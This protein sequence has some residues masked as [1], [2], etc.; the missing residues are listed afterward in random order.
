MSNVASA[1]TW[2]VEIASGI[3]RTMTLDELDEAYQR[4]SVHESTRVRQSG[5]PNWSTLAAVAGA[6]DADYGSE[7]YTPEP[8]NSISPMQV[9]VPPPPAVPREFAHLADLDDD[10]E[11]F[12]PK[13]TKKAAVAAAIVGV[14]ALAGAV[15]FGV[16]R[17]SSADLMQAAAGAAVAAPPPAVTALPA[18]AETASDTRNLSDDQRRALLEADQKRAAEAEKKRAKNAAHHAGGHRH[19]KKS[20]DGLLKGGDKFDP[21]NGNL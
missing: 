7:S 17:A 8:T 6:E 16:T 4:G 11:L 18:P 20:G 14:A 3:V 1:D 12:R 19:G 5:A 13:K 21:L 9:T 2:D 10:E 15:A